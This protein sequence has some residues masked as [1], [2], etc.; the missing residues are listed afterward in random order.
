[1]AFSPTSITI[2]KIDEGIT[3]FTVV[4]DYIIKVSGF[5]LAPDVRD[6]GL[7][8]WKSWKII[9]PDN[10]SIMD[11]WQDDIERKIEKELKEAISADKKNVQ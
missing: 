10:M 9:W 11:P 6:V 2:D 5:K 4:F 1:M 8:K 7:F 3:D